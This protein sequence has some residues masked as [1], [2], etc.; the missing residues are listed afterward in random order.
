[1]CSDLNLEIKKESKVLN[2]EIDLSI[3]V[4]MYNVEDY[5]VETLNSIRGVKNYIVEYLL[6]DDGSTDKTVEFVQE[7]LLKNNVDYTLIINKNEGPSK[8][9]NLGV[10]E[11]RGKFITFFDSDDIAL[12]YVYED[13]IHVMNIYNV[14]FTITRGISFNQA[15][16]DVYEFPD[17]YVWDQ[18]IGNAKLKILTPF[19]EPRMARL[20]PS[21]V[22]RVF[23]REFLIGNIITFPE[24]FFFEDLSFHV[25]CIQKA[26][27]VAFLNKTLLMY[28]VNRDGQTTGSF[29]TKRKDILHI[30]AIIV[31]SYQNNL[32]SDEVWSNFVGLLVRMVIWCAENCDYKDKHHFIKQSLELFKELPDDLF[33]IYIKQYAYNQWEK[34]ICQAY[35]DRD[36][37]TLYWA[38]EG[39]YPNIQLEATSDQNQEVD[40]HLVH[41]KVEQLLSQQRD[42]WANDRFNV[43][44]GKIEQI[45]S[46]QFNYKKIIPLYF[47]NKLRYIKKQMFKG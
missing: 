19:Q 4:P 10:A 14:D 17:Y 24:G 39:G 27:K 20:E 31:N 43:L 23:R 32:V 44:N 33:E 29:G 34:N 37:E 1:M 42:G 22:M 40:I 35:L 30:L 18:I 36:L 12:A 2:Q 11:A 16:Q 7:W 13:I 46:Q 28:R 41:N 6:I 25:E 26:Q 21:A 15:T 9:R 5:I 3:I 45:I 38:A 47:R 8:S